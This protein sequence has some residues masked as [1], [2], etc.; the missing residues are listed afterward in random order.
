MKVFLKIC[1]SLITSFCFSQEQSSIGFESLYQKES[2]SDNWY[3]EKGKTSY[4]VFLDT[5]D[6][7]KQSISI[8]S[9]S[10]NHS[11]CSVS[12]NIANGYKGDTLVLSAFIKSKDIKEGDVKIL[13]NL[14]KK[15]KSIKY[16][17]LESYTVTGTTTWKEYSVKLALDPRADTIVVSS[18][19]SGL[20]QAWFKDFKLTL[21]GENIK[22][23]QA[24][25][26]E[27]LKAD[28]DHE[29]DYGSKIRID[30]LDKL[31][32][33]RLASLS[34]AWGELKYTNPKIAK[35]E[36]N[37]DYELFRIM[38]IIYKQDF[39]DKLE[40]WKLSF[41]PISTEIP[42]DNYYIDFYPNVGN[43][44]FENEKVYKDISFD[45]QGYRL[46]ALFRY[47]NAI[48]YFYPYKNLIPKNWD[49]VLKQYIQKLLSSK[50]ELQ[51]KLDLMRLTKE[52]EDGHSFFNA[53]GDTLMNDFLGI[54]TVPI[55][56]QFIENKLVVTQLDKAIESQFKIKVGD[57]IKTIAGKDV[58][59][60]LKERE[61]FY[62]YSNQNAK[63]YNTMP[64]MLRTNDDKLALT[65][66]SE[67]K[68]FTVFLPTVGLNDFIYYKGVL[69]TFKELEGNIGYINIGGLKTGDLTNIMKEYKTKKGIVLDFRSYPNID[70]GELMKFFTPKGIP[71]VRNVSPNSIK[72]GKEPISSKE[73][74]YGDFDNFYPGKVSIL[75]DQSTMSASEY[76]IMALQTS[77]NVKVFGTQTAGA[78]G[79]I[80]ILMLPGNIQVIFSGIGVYYPDGTNAQKAGIKVDTYVCPTIQALKQNRDLILEK[81]IQNLL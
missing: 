56:I 31:T 39:D 72:L 16:A 47:W 42:K 70:L 61:I 29:F 71:F 65:I 6:Q 5:L 4:D 36:Y 50:D 14:L 40:M 55:R 60:V 64:F 62:P 57:Q 28:L 41:G 52:L 24:K 10:D 53:K 44:V 15:G 73:L 77:S 1:L 51:Y 11:F 19:I 45:D 58:L 12:N 18:G 78:D 54:K 69:D 33:N 21:D 8:K 3:I 9:S 49:D 30:K 75:V 38:P 7:N 27:P 81:G 80:S 35:A 46:L 63:L 59:E 25:K 2:K 43:A 48:E 32:I 20:G 22:D 23:L 37:W 67:D 68:E 76:Y 34:K 26:K 79:N 66:K 74:T 13:I 17:L